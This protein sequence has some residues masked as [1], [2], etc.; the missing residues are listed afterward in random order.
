[1]VLL[2]ALGEHNIGPLV[3]V[4]LDIDDPLPRDASG[5]VPIL[6]E[7]YEACGFMSHVGV[8]SVAE[9]FDWHDDHVINRRPI[10]LARLHEDPRHNR[11]DIPRRVGCLREVYC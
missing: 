3:P 10:P 2:V 5:R 8:T 6:D 9:P 1:M 4:A 7:K 11:A